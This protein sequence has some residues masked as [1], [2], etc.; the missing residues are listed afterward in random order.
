MKT[1]FVEHLNEQNDDITE[2]QLKEKIFDYIKDNLNLDLEHIAYA[3]Q[4]GE[5]FVIYTN[6]HL[7]YL[8]K[9]RIKAEY[10]GTDF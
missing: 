3:E 5:D 10:D 9:F 4:D 6:E 8:T 2:E 7:G 1:K